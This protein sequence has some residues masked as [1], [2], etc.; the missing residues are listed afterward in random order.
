MTGPPYS[1]GVEILA[2]RAEG[3][4]PLAF[5]NETL[6][7]ATM[8]LIPA[9]IAL[10]YSLANIDRTKAAVG[11]GI[12]AMVIPVL[13]VVFTIHGRLIYPIYDMRVS[14]PAIAEVIPLWW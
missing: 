1:N 14:T 7:F 3:E 6:F 2:W 12:L 4:L 11:C 9:V 5:T 13:F 10:Y 8:F